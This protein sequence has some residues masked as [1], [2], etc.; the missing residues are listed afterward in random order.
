MSF[1]KYL[2]TR[3]L[4]ACE[5][6]RA[7][8]LDV[9]MVSMLASGL[10]DRELVRRW[11][12]NYGLQQGIKAE[13]RDAIIDCFLVFATEHKKRVSPLSDTDI[14]QIYACL[15]TKFYDAVARGWISAT[16]KL[17]WCLYP[18]DF[19]IYDSF[20]MR[21]LAVMQCLDPVLAG[22]ERVSAIPEI[23]STASIPAIVDGYMVYQSMV[24]ILLKTHQPALDDLRVKNKEKY[25]YDIRI[26]DKLLWMIGDPKRNYPIDVE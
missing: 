5:K 13:D 18:N 2:A 12:Y 6:Q 22:Y 10:H 25:Q 4:T 7:I 1:E 24:K 16:S 17:L 21:M 8:S 15:F 26:I 19:V 9:K 23:K 20:V 3:Y 11:M 14:R